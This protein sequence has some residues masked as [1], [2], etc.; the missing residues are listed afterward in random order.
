M[1]DIKHNLKPVILRFVFLVPVVAFFIYSTYLAHAIYVERA[2]Y[3][4]GANF[5]VELLSKDRTWPIADDSKHIRLFVNFLN[6]FPVVFALQSGVTSLRVLKIFFG[7]GLFLIPLCLYLYSL[8]LSHRANDYR[9]FFFSTISLV[10][11]AI[12]SD[13]FVLNQAFTSLALVWVLIHS[14]L[15][16]L[17]IKWM[18]WV[19]FLSISL[20]LFRSHE[21]LILWGGI[22]FLGALCVIV[23]R[24]RC[25]VSNRNL[26]VYTIGVLGLLQSGFVAFWQLTH[27][28]SEQTSAFL[29]LMSLLKLSEL[30]VGN[31][32]ISLLMSISVLLIFLVQYEFERFSRNRYALRHIYLGGLAFITVLMLFSGFSALYDF[33]LTNPPREY[34]YRFLITFGSSAWM[35]L[36]IGFVIFNKTLNNIS[37]PLSIIV[38]SVGIVSASLWQLSNSIQ[39]SIFSNA[40]VEVHKNSSSLI[41]DPVEV[42]EKLIS[43]GHEDVYKYR[44]GWAWPVFGM[45][46]QDSGEVEKLFR[47]E[48]YENYFKPP[49]HLP[50]IMMS[51]R[52]IGSE[53]AGFYTFKRFS[54]ELK[55]EVHHSGN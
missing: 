4:D 31:T 36:A 27:P 48:G 34:S 16:N 30:W 49:K 41:I 21:S 5:F 37:R 10:S 32:R 7:A 22:L 26:L 29:Q 53:G 46:L 17:K 9:V 11:C 54:R 42:H 3:A 28:V 13:I 14:L 43:L 8:Y 1:F 39:W 6:Q 51:G 55:S 24:F 38:I 35:L 18:D 40:T 47:P 15:L 44:W 52:E 12:P 45:S 25:V 50:F 2:L 23:F 19:V 20:I 33:S